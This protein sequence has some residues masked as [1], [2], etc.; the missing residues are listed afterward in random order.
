MYNRSDTVEV[1]GEPEQTV[2]NRL[3]FP[4]VLNEGVTGKDVKDRGKQ[5]DAV[6]IPAHSGNACFST[7][8]LL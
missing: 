3:M 2:L 6:A 5:G 7:G 4:V 1:L 8:T